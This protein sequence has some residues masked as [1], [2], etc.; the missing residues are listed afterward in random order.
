MEQARRVGAS[1]LAIVLR[2]AALST[3]LELVD[4]GDGSSRVLMED[5]KGIE[6]FV[7]EAKRRLAWRTQTNDHGASHEVWAMRVD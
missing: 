1:S 5:V 7:D 4:I 2:G 6:L 3:R